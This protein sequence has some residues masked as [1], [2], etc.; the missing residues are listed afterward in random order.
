MRLIMADDEREKNHN[1]DWLTFLSV[2]IL[3]QL[4][5]ALGDP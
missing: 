1:S 2:L 5:T 3:K 4:T